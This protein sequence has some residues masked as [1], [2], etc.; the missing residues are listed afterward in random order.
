MDAHDVIVTQ[1]IAQ[2]QTYLEDLRAGRPM[3]RT[4]ALQLGAP[5]GAS[6]GRRGSADRHRHPTRR[7]ARLGVTVD[8][9]PALA[10]TAGGRPLEQTF[11]SVVRTLSMLRRVCASVISE[12]TQNML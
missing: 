12:K 11:G 5:L 7:R 8:R 4:A 10:R 1:L 3:N 2:V 6:H 9:L